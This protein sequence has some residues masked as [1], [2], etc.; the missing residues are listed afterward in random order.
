MKLIQDLGMRDVGTKQPIRFGLYECTMCLSHFEARTANIK[1]GNT[2]SCGCGKYPIPNPLRATT[3]YS[4]WDHMKQRCLNV[5]NKRYMRYGGRGIT[6]D[7]NWLNSFP[8]FSKWAES[9]GYTD[10]LTIDRVDNDRSYTPGNCEF[11]SIEENL[12]RRNRSNG[13]KSN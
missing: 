8:T 3:M 4:S 13:W 9:A 2:G 6:I 1:S 12:K 11:V 7:P 10:D 5:N